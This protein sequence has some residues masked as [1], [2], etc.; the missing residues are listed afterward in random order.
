MKCSGKRYTQDSIRRNIRILRVSLCLTLYPLHQFVTAQ[1]GR[2]QS[3]F[4][5]GACYRSIT[6]NEFRLNGFDKSHLLFPFRRRKQSI[7]NRHQ[8][9]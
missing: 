7:S 6:I 2:E 5:K 8:G 9:K 4:E 3:K 1:F